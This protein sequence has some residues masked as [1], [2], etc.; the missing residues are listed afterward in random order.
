MLPFWA[1]LKFLQA[2][3][4]CQAC[5]LNPIDTVFL[6]QDCQDNMVWLPKAF[7][8]QVDSHTV[9][10]QSATYYSLP[11]SHAITDF[12]DTEDMTCLPLLL[13]G[14][15]RLSGYLTDLPA[16]S[17]ILPVPTPTSR[18]VE[19]GFS[20]VFMLA[21]YLSAMCEFD[22]YTG[23]SRPYGSTHQ[24]GLDKLA[25]LNNIKNAFVM[26]YPPPS[27]S[28]VIFDDVA[29]TGATVSEVAK[30][31]L[32]HS[33]HYNIHAVCLAHGSLDGQ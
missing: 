3:D 31:L 28:V 23:V 18:L 17:V 29:T 22:I 25:R 11:M 27:D 33:D 10:V 13:H 2:L 6:C 12:K 16:G 26:E 5:H 20:P 15:Y 32:E 24:R 30:T 8:L 4:V 9:T 7:E 19:R 21:R 14:L 1:G